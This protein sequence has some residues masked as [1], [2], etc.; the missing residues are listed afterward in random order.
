MGERP[1]DVTVAAE[2]VRKYQAAIDQFTLAIALSPQCYR[3]WNGR[4]MCFAV[5]GD[6]KRCKEDVLR[7][8]QLHPDFVRGW[9]LLVESSSK[10]GLQSEALQHVQTALQHVC[11]CPELL[12]LQAELTPPCSIAEPIGEMSQ[13]TSS[14]ECSMGSSECSKDSKEAPAESRRGRPRSATRFISS[15]FASTFGSLSRTSSP[16]TFCTPAST[17]A[18]SSRSD[19]PM[20]PNIPRAHHWRSP[21][22]PSAHSQPTAR[23]VRPSSAPVGRRREAEQHKNAAP[24]WGSRARTAPTPTAAAGGTTPRGVPGPGPPLAPTELGQGYN[25]WNMRQS[26]SLSSLAASSRLG[27]TL[28]SRSCRSRMRPST[29]GPRCYMSSSSRCRSASTAASSCAWA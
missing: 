8:T 11:G 4:A 2:S 21:V 29:A 27:I 9:T 24:R 7:V 1:E 19:T 13:Q 3:L 10:L 5:L 16:S 15:L 26:A 28:C 14:S 6:W 22:D 17:P 23:K 12:R 18:S 25:A 20:P